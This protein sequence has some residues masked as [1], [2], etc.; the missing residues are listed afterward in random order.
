MAELSSALTLEVDVQRQSSESRGLPSVAP[1]L[2]E[3]LRLAVER[4][5]E[6]RAN[7]R[8][9][10]TLS[11][12]GRRLKLDEERLRV[13]TELETFSNDYV[14]PLDE[15]IE[16]ANRA[17]S[18]AVAASTPSPTAV[19]V[20]VRDLPRD[21]AALLSLWA[22]AT[23]RE[24]ETLIAASEAAGRVPVKRGDAWVWT[25]LVPADQ[26]AIF[27]QAQRASADPALTA[28]LRGLERQRAVL[29]GL[30]GTVRS[31]V[32]KG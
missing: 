7:V 25:E 5:E 29:R 17:L 10:Q 30:V 3:R 19:E 20:L 32:T 27:R 23:P 14:S 22:S 13:A 21:E 15:E 18:A 11:E 24:R 1:A 2:V 6:G 31:L 12:L 4:Y 8:A 28:R 26:V 9:D 16:A